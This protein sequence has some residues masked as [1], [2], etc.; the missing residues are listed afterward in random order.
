[1][2]I[3]IYTFYI[4]IYICIYIY[5]YKDNYYLYFNALQHVFYHLYDYIYDNQID[6]YLSVHTLSS[7]NNNSNIVYNKIQLTEKSLL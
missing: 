2:Y 6:N 1:M 3:C 7:E 4:Y 5:I